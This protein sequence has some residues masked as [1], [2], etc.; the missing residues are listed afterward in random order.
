M[1]DNTEL[2]MALK[3]QIV[4]LKAS[5]EQLAESGGDIPAVARNM[6]RVLAS[7][8]MLELNFVDALDSETDS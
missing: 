7:I 4:Q 6:S 1:T 2:F 3:D 8:K 5:A